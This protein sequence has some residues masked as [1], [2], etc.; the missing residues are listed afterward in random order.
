MENIEAKIGG[1]DIHPP[2]SPGRAAFASF[3]GTA[4]EYYDFFLYGTAA[5]LIF[6]QLFF[7]NV[8]PVIGTLSAFATFGAGFLF[9]P[10]GG[11]FF[12][13]FGDK[14]GRKAML[15]ITLLTMGL[16]TFLIG[17]LPGYD[18]IGILAPILL[19]L[20]RAVQ[21]F[22]VGGEWAGAALMSVEHAPQGRQGFFGSWTNNGAVGGFLLSTVA[23]GIFSG[24]PEEQFLAWGWRIPFLFS[25][26]VVAVGLFIRLRVAETPMFEEVKESHTEARLPI[27]EVFRS[28]PKNMLLI[29]GCMVGP[30]IGFFVAT[31]FTLSYA[32]E[33]L[34]ID[35]STMLPILI[36]STII[37]LLTLPLYGALSDRI[38]RRRMYK[39]A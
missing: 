35:R 19:V 37:S 24:L 27:L 20:L 22:A 11:V 39:R 25:A 28:Y 36:V 29:V 31:V 21:G 32:T 34:N 13:H 5:A 1:E 17:L 15:V 26:V 8:S 30:L 14:I 4:T 7:P 12:G 6:G 10:L 9:R 2:T 23:F 18:S 33:Q 3:I 16:A 38:G